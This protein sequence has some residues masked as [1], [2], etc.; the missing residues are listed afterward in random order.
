MGH[1]GLPNW[2]TC[3]LREGE[4]LEGRGIELVA[5]DKAPS[6]LCTSGARVFVL[7]ASIRSNLSI[8]ACWTPAGLPSVTG[9]L[10]WPGGGC[11]Y[12]RIVFLIAKPS[13]IRHSIF[14]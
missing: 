10:L 11:E 4:G 5:L 8:G 3:G 6:G 14:I 12:V 1:G 7:V 13:L 2:S 9:P